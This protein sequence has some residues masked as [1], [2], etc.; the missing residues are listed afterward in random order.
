MR[1]HKKED[2]WWHNEKVISRFFENERFM[3]RYMN[4]HM[5]YRFDKRRGDIENFMHTLTDELIVLYH[6][7]I[8][9]F[10][11]KEVDSLSTSSRG[12]RTGISYSIN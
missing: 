1:I 8:I 12:E 6:G 7:H 4:G 3:E 11:R 10:R 9:L 2:V 5:T